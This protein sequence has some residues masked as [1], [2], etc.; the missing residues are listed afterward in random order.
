MS[1]PAASPTS[2]PLTPEQARRSLDGGARDRRLYGGYALLRRSPLHRWS[3]SHSGSCWSPGFIFCPG[4]L[5]AS[6][7]SWPKRWQVGPDVPIPRGNASGWRWAV[8]AALAIFPLFALLTWGFYGKVC[9]GDLEHPLTSARG[10]ELTPGDG[11]GSLGSWLGNVDVTRRVLAARVVLAGRLG[12]I[13]RAGLPQAVAVGAVC[14]RAARRGVSPRL[15]DERAGAA[16]AAQ[17]R[18]LFGVPFGWA[19]VISSMLFALGTS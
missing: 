17:A 6:T 1:D 16:L 18:K 3:P 7:P 8:Y 11:T 15:P 4:C 14:G 12:P 10:R 19:A 9:T 5:C 2:V 13:L